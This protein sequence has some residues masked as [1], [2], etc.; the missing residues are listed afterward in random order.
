MNGSNDSIF[1][2]GCLIASRFRFWGASKKLN[3][4]QIGDLPPKIVHAVRSLLSNKSYLVTVNGVKDDAKRFIKA[5]TLYYGVD[6]L[7][8]IPKDKIEFVDDGLKWRKGLAEEA[9]ENLIDHLEACKADY[10]AEY[11]EFYNEANYPT[12][13]QLRDNFC[14]TWSFRTFGLPDEGLMLLSP[15]MYKAEVSKFQAEMQD[16]RDGLVS[17]VTKEFYGRIEKLRDQCLNGSISSSTVTS[18]SSTLEKF[19]DLW[20]GYVAHEELQKAVADIREY[21][22][23]TDADMLKADDEFREAIGGAMS[24]I[25]NQIKNSPDERLTRKLAL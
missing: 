8:F 19:D 12:P 15:E 22:D 4:D 25:V 23:G 11:P 10:R 24:D 13:A 5:N 14:F 20:S 6:G 2:E 7:D 16:M 18:I 17:M 9:V 21:M 3:P 1:N